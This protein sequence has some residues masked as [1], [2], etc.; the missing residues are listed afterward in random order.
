MT[1]VL[2][3]CV[4]ICLYDRAQRIGGM[5]H[6]LLPHS[7]GPTVNLRYGNMSIDQLIAEMHNLGAR[8][9]KLEAKIFGG[10]AVLAVGTPADS[11]GTQNV[12]MAL[13]RM[14]RH[15]IRVTAR[16][17]GGTKGLLIRFSTSTGDVMVRPIEP[18]AH[19]RPAGEAA[20]Y[21][22]KLGG[23]DCL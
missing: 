16:R 8:V 13:E 11:V 19:F 2:G 1:T 12:R 22:S 7:A 14:R 6:Y 20:H 3:S 21:D 5:N 17:T 18:G 10:A 15:R 23:P 4:A 9:D